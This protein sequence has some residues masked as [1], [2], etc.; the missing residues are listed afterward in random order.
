MEAGRA[1]ILSDSKVKVRNINLSTSGISPDQ[2]QSSERWYEDKE[3][4][5][6]YFL[7]LTESEY[8]TFK[9]TD[10]Y[11]EVLAYQ[12]LLSTF[13]S[14]DYYILVFNQNPFLNK[15]LSMK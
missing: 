6:T 1:T 7:M 11:K 13:Q 3:G 10:I 15:Q 8:A 4:Q 9:M 2:Y 14:G 5:E 12:A